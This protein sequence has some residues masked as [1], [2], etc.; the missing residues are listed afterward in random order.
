MQQRPKT[1]LNAVASAKPC[2]V[3]SETAISRASIPPH[4]HNEYS[5]ESITYAKL[6]RKIAQTNGLHVKSHKQSSYRA[7]NSIPLLRIND[8]RT[9][10]LQNRTNNGLISKIAQ[11][12]ELANS[13]YWVIDPKDQLGVTG[14]TASRKISIGI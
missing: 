1:P 5:I 9:I 2:S 8:L 4:L 6:L 3:E 12:K 14:R 11:T 13:S 7:Q 10:S